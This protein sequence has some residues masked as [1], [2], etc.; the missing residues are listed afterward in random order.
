MCQN[1]LLAFI[2]SQS[3]THKKYY[4]HPKIEKC[5]PQAEGTQ[6]SKQHEI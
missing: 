2:Q 1:T 6:T 4:K 5:K 3:Q